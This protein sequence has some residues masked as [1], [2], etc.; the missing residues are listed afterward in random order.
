METVSTDSLAVDR[1]S[2]NLQ[3]L[4]TIGSLWVMFR[5]RCEAVDSTCGAGII[6]RLLTARVALESL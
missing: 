5:G 1:K 2:H 6:V 3:G 4:G